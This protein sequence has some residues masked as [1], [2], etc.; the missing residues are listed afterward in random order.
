MNVRIGMEVGHGETM[1]GRGRLTVEDFYRGVIC[2]DGN[3]WKI[4][5]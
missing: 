4:I 1:E 3:T 5:D 2:S